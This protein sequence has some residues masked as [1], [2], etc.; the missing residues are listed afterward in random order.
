MASAA[1]KPLS[2]QA[3]KTSRRRGRRSDPRPRPVVDRGLRIQNA[4]KSRKYV[5]VLPGVDVGQEGYYASIGYDVERYKEGG[6]RLP[7]VRNP[8]IG[9][10][11]TFQGLV[12]MSIDKE[13][14]EEIEAFGEY[15]DSGQ[16]LADQ[17]EEKMVER[18]GGRDALRGLTGG[19]LIPVVNHT[20]PAEYEDIEG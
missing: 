19:H 2:E 18:S 9:D 15:G 17:I 5:A 8:V 6:I 10:R 1:A 16:D 20:R 11:V 4:D 14:A 12:I 3:P 13:T 7:R